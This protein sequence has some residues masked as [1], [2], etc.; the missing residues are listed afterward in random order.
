MGASHRRKLRAIIISHEKGD[1]KG[2]RANRDGT[3]RKGGNR[4]IGRGRRAGFVLGT[5]E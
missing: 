2:K 4:R 5:K 3:G 1:K